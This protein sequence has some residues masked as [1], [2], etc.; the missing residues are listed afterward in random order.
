MYVACRNLITK[1]GR[2]KI[3]EEVVDAPSWKYPI[4]VSHLNLGWIKWA[5]AGAP[6]PPQTQSQQKPKPKVEKKASTTPVVQPPTQSLACTKCD[7]AGF[8]SERA[9]KIHVTSKHKE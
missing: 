4:L 9:L 5:G 3:G 7:K 8:K 6:P 2:V 1:S